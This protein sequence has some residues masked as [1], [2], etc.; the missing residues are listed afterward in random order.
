MANGLH[1]G[2]MFLASNTPAYLFINPLIN[3]AEI[4]TFYARCLLLNDRSMFKATP[5]F[6]GS[7]RLRDIAD[8]TALHKPNC[9]RSPCVY[10]AIA[11]HERVAI[12][13]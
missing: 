1:N 7:D 8:G 11:C 12:D 5:S 13:K 6:A 10:T 4:D 3:F 9:A 2:G